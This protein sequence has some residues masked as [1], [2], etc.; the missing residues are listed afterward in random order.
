M[1]NPHTDC[2]GAFKVGDTIIDKPYVR[3][4]NRHEPQKKFEYVIEALSR[5]GSDVPAA[6]LVIP[7]PFTPHTP[8][9]I[10]VA[11]ELG[12]E[13]RVLFLGQISEADL[14]RLYREAAVYCYPAPEADLGMGVIEAMAW[15]VPV[16]AWDDACPPVT[17][18]DGETAVLVEPD[19]AVA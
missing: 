2:E 17:A 1:L 7:G 16:V 4:T 6:T 11:E 5:I 9:L 15:G 3:I 18:L 19:N 8:K 13:E 14:Q 10:A 12:L